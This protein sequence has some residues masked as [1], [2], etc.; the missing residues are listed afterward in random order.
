MNPGVLDY[1]FATI[2]LVMVI[3]CLIKGFITEL[4]AVAAIGGGIVGGILFSAA[5]GDFL[6]GVFG[7]SPWNR[8]IAFLAIFLSVYLILKIAEGL[9]YRLIEAVHLE[10]LDRAL[11][12][13][14][15]LGEGIVLSVLILLVLETQPFVDTRRIID[16]SLFAQFITGVL[17]ETQIPG[18]IPLGESYKGV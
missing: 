14:W 4:A 12:F 3:R 2:M 6:A 8:V 17:P 15:G 7:D 10:N 18:H 9:L 13:F 1:I 5:G 16:E 11:G